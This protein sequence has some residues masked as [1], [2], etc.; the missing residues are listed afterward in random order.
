MSGN[1]DV[2]CVVSAAEHKIYVLDFRTLQAIY[3]R[4]GSFTIIRH[5]EQ[6]TYCYLLELC[7]IRQFGGLIAVVEY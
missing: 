2:F 5:A 3:K 6:D 1:T 7:R 4:Y